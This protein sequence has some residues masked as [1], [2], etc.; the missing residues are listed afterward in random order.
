[1]DTFPSQSNWQSIKLDLAHRVRL[2]RE[3][4]YGEN[5]GPLLAQEIG[6][7]FRTWVNYEEGCTIP[8]QAI[9]QFIEI[10]N[11]DPHWLL[12]GEGEPYRPTR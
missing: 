5:G 1:M 12:T 6:V 9:L 8:A 10:T 2:I 4:L 3:E 7:P 11:A